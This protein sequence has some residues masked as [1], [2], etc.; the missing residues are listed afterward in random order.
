MP[1]VSFNLHTQTCALPH[2]QSAGDKLENSN[3]LQELFFHNSYSSIVFNS[4]IKSIYLFF[5]T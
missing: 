1:D 2:M 3:S 5:L 4:S